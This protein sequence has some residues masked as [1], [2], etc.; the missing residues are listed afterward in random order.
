M[1]QP[2][3]HSFG[4]RPSCHRS[5]LQKSA[6][7]SRN[8]QALR[9]EQG[10]TVAIT[11]AA[12]G[13]CESLL[14]STIQTQRP[15][16]SHKRTL[17][18]APHILPHLITIAAVIVSPLVVAATAVPPLVHTETTG[19]FLCQRLMFINVPNS[20]TSKCQAYI[21]KRRGFLPI[22][23]IDANPSHCVSCPHGSPAMH[24]NAGRLLSKAACGMSTTS[25]IVG[26][27]SRSSVGVY[28]LGLR[29]LFFLIVCVWY[30]GIG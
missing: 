26:P 24:V 7:C 4:S 25:P 9:S 16:P 23:Y 2:L 20:I 14:H 29:A 12:S 15:C 10:T 18:A 28:R 30:T 13:T 21:C 6:S 5:P 11:A 27:R 1:R 22:T 19:Q 8:Q 3:R 17:L